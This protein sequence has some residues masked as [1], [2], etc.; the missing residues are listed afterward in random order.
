MTRVLITGPTGFIAFHLAKLLQAESF[1][2]HGDDEI[3]DYCDVSV[4]VVVVC[5]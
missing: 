1:Q 5:F 3:I 2:F 4:D